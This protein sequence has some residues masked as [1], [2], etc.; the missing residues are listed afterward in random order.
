MTK[1]ELAQ[2][3]AYVRT[4][5][6]EGRQAPLVGGSYLILFGTLLAV[7]YGMHWA[8]LMGALGENGDDVLGYIWIGYFVFAFAGFALLVRRVH[9]KPGIA[10]MAN[11]V[12]RLVWRSV[13]LAITAVV[14]GCV[15]RM[16]IA[17]DY[18]APNAI[19]GA[20]FASFG[21]ALGLTAAVSG[22]SWLTLVSL[23]SF[24]TSATLFLY[25][26]EPWAYLLA[27][28]ASVVVLLM[29]GIVLVRREPS[30]IV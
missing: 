15:G 17:Q 6:E 29:P 5:A 7:S 23:L 11:K 2:E 25:I 9:R 3:I 20:S 10:S 8:T 14:I 24:A 28:I 13:G 16:I 21:I 18:L 4:L 27:S 19:M 26:N 12:D 1:E 30:P 22:Q